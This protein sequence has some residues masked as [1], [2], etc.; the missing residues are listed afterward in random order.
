MSINQSTTSIFDCRVIKSENNKIMYYLTCSELLN[1]SGD[2]ISG[3]QKKRTKFF[4]RF[5]R[6]LDGVNRYSI[7]KTS[8]K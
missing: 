8:A 4:T 6:E 1:G 5:A 7:S 2:Q 3:F